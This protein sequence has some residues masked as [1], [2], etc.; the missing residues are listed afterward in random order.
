MAGLASWLQMRSQLAKYV[1]TGVIDFCLL[2]AMIFLAQI[3]RVSELALP[4]RISLPL[5][6]I[7][8]ILSILSLAAF[9][10]YQN[11]ARAY[12]QFIERKIIVSQTVAVFVWVGI[13]WFAGT[14]G[15]ARS[16]VVI[17]LA[18]SVLALLAIRR[19]AAWYMQRS[20]A[21]HVGG[22]RIPVLIF[23]A[24]AEGIALAETLSRRGQLNPKAFVE[25]DYTLFGRTVH[26]IAVSPI[27][28]LSDVIKRHKPV[29]ILIAKTDLARESKRQMVQLFL[30]NNLKVKILAGVGGLID[31]TKDGPEL[32]NVSVEDLLGRD[33]VPPDQ[34][35]MQKAIG[36]SCVMVTG[37]GGS[38][39]SEIVRQVAAFGATKIIMVDI[40]EFA[41]FEIHREL[42]GKPQI[43]RSGVV[44]VPILGDVRDK[45]QML[46]LMQTHK[47]EV[48]FHA[49][50]YKHV[51]MVQ[52]NP[53]AGARTNVW[54]SLATAEAAVQGKVRLFVLVST[55]KA[56]RSSNIM[57][58]TKRW[59][60]LIVQALAL[61]GGHKTSFAIVRFGNVLGSSGSVV[62]LFREQLSR[63]GPL[64][65]TA[66]EATRYFMLIPEAAQLVVQ[67]GAMAVQ[68]EVFVLDMGEPMKILQ[69][70]NTMIELAGLTP[71]SPENPDGDIEIQFIGLREGEKLHEELHIGNDLQ[72][73]P[74]KRIWLAREQALPLAEVRKQLTVLD[75]HITNSR[76][77]AAT[78]LIMEV[79]NRTT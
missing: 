69:L 73:T 64:T 48:V 43:A 52:E 3:L 74:N 40:S 59:A 29:E 62:P 71:R 61:G 72:L 47:V 28:D 49:A 18:I 16:V 63:G 53:F 14:E 13:L 76:T 25:T 41:L 1:I 11:S 30:A 34:S 60:E 39:G 45:N 54:G 27:D 36:N 4:P 7:A 58:A 51:R 32:R 56:V 68:G 20:T 35:L 79:A 6:L 77:E 21:K 22:Q 42:E 12:T 23:G 15:F 65:I 37:A 44:L 67:A 78:T 9:G 10:V 50:A 5:Y 46:D 19:F 57:G 66:P 75:N 2:T 70:A 33:P 31:G 24:N 8:P 55:D 17:Y 26:G 38:I